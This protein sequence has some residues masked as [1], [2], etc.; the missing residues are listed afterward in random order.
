MAHMFFL[1]FCCY[2][3]LNISHLFIPLNYSSKVN[4]YSS[5]INSLTFPPRYIFPS[6]FLAL[7]KKFQNQR[8]S[9]S[10]V[11]CQHLP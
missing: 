8:N 9:T 1:L 7:T 10:N 11:K 4:I 3:N 6:Y 2:I 5:Q